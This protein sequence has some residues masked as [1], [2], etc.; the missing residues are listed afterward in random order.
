MADPRVEAYAR[1]LVEYCLDVRPRMQVLLSTSPLARPL[2]EACVRAIARRGAYVIPRL[3][4][5]DSTLIEKNWLAE[6]PVELLGELPAVDRHLAEHVDAVLG[7]EAPENT[8][9]DAGLGSERLTA[10]RTASR[11]LLDR[12]TAHELPWVLCQYPTHALAQDAGMSLAAFADVLYA[13]CLIDWEE[14]GERMRRVAERLQRAEELRVVA[15]GTDVR[16]AVAGRPFESSAGKYN[17]P[18]GEVFT[19][20]IEDSADGV[21]HFSEFPAVY[22]GR[23]LRGIRLEFREG[24]VVDAS[25]ESEEAFLHEVLDKDAGARR[26]GEVGIGCNPGITRYMKNTLFDEKMDGT[27]HLALGQ[28][29]T[30]LGGLNESVIHWDLVKDLRTDG[31]LEADGEVVQEAGVWRL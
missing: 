15:P 5:S 10:A 17:M 31:R 25:A 4:W 18:D 12:V 30:D 21:V 26:L 9:A 19:A 3:T 29:Y 13:A 23:E 20:P 2:Y 16:L 24:V 28:S 6:A 11:P 8:R 1:L 7:I 22:E 14:A 27:V